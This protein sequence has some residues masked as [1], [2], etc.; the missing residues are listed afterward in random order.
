MDILG[1]PTPEKA[2]IDREIPNDAPVKLGDTKRR[3]KQPPSNPP[4][5]PSSSS[6]RE[7]ETMSFTPEDKVPMLFRD[8][9]VT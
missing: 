2:T 3:R 9:L 5:T 6:K 7:G 8:L 1:V 4:S